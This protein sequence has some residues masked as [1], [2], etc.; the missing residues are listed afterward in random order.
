MADVRILDKD[1]WDID[2]GSPVRIHWSDGSVSEPREIEA[3]EWRLGTGWTPRTR[4][5]LFPVTADVE[6]NS[7]RAQELE[8]V[9]EDE[10]RS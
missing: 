3:I 5:H 10:E 2:V 8:L 1:G 6:P 9:A 4:M 7:Y